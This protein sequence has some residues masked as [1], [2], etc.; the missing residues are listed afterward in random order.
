MNEN[1]TNFIYA[2]TAG[3]ISR[4]ITSPLERLKILY[5]NKSDI[6]FNIVHDLHH[7]QKNEGFFSMLNGNGINCLRIF[8]ESAIR[9]SSFNICKKYFE[10]HDINPNVNYFLSGSL[11]GIISSSIIYPLE[12]IRSKLSAQS[13]NNL[14]NGILDC[15]IKTYKTGGIPQFYKGCS[16]TLLGMIPFQGTNFLTYQY[17]KNN[18]TNTTVNLLTFGCI[19]GITSVSV[20]YPFDVIKRR[21]QLSNELGNPQY[22]NTVNCLIYIYIINL[23]YK[24][25]IKDCCH[26]I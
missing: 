25:F 2:G 8:P 4:T 13:N 11:S 19:S 3:I 18:Y 10:E 26:V 14:Y 9:Y 1:I 6:K 16:V 23:V 20:S 5:Q 22:K 15:T 12:T 21:L 17:L 7:L 24:D